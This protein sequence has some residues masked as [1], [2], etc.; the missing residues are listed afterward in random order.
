MH[1]PSLPHSTQLV[2]STDWLAPGQN[3]AQELFL[4][5]F[6]LLTSVGWKGCENTM[7]FLLALCRP[8]KILSS[9]N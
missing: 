8:Y 6:A 3:I 1:P 2:S 9:V 7:P 5:N 4:L